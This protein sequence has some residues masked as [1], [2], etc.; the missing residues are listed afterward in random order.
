MRIARFNTGTIFSSWT[1]LAVADT[2]RGMGHEVF[3]GVIPTNEHG[4]VMHQLGP[5]QYRR[6]VAGMPT[7]EQLESCEVIL[8]SGPEYIAAWLHTLYGQDAWLRLKARRVAFYLE[9]SQ[10]ED[11]S[12]H[13]ESFMPWYDVHFFPDPKDAERLGGHH[14][15]ASVDTT[16]FK[17]CALHA[18]GEEERSAEC[19]SHRLAEKKY[20]AAFVGSLYGK[21]M[22]YLA[23]LLPLI[24]EIDFR[25]GGVAALDIGGE[26][27]RE[28]AELLVRN[29]RQMKI[30][31]ALPSNNATI[32]V[33]RPFETMACGTFLLTYQTDDALFKDGVHCRMYNPEEPEMLAEMIRYYLAHEQEREAIAACGMEEV[34]RN[35]S[36]GRRLEEVLAIAG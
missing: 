1:N 14:L 3:E 36:L 19:L 4:A 31:V 25:A 16:M 8:V 32:M 29:L 6:A 23:R 28:W 24:P 12:Y 10:R 2:L 11:V 33:S 22:Q 26:C 34:R 17:P 15:M 18:C 9:S 7:L 5:H 27:H 21:R 35:Y 30:H 13:Y 20:D